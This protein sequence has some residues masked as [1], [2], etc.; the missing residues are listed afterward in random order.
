V[1]LPF[2]ETQ[3][4]HAIGSVVTATKLVI[5]GVNLQKTN[6]IKISRNAL[7]WKKNSLVKIFFKTF[8]L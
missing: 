3:S 4:D 6:P 1:H 7:F 5:R 8:W 2:K